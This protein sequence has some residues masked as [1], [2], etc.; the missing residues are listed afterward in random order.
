MNGGANLLPELFSGLVAAVDKGDTEKM[1]GLQ[2]KIEDFQPEYGTP[3]TSPG[4][5]R[6][7]KYGLSR[8][9]L[10]KN[11]MAFPNLPREK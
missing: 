5:I 3:C 1:N 10:I 6:A 7:L 2:K 4:V 9:G 8:K 11:I